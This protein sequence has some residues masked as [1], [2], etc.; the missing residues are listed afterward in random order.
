M[1][2]INKN[3]TIQTEL[4]KNINKMPEV[5]VDLIKEYIPKCILVFTNRENYNLYHYL[6]L[7]CIKN[8]ENCVRD[9]IRRDNEFVF[10]KIIREKYHR[11]TDIKQ[12]RYKNMIFKNYFYFIINFCIEHESEN[13]RRKINIFLKEHGLDKNLHKK[14]VIKY[15]KWKD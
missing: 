6:I 5:I 10:D 4:I 15:I 9:M 3:D 2:T 13:C 12:Y 8:Y 1:S 7:N 14:N 11:W